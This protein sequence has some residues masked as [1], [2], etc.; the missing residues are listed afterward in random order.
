MTQN[1]TEKAQYKIKTVENLASILNDF[2]SNMKIVHCHGVFDLLHIGHIRHFE[3]AKSLGDI[4]VVTVTP[5]KYVNKGPHRPAFT[6]RLRVE[7]VASLSCVDYVAVNEWPTAVETIK[8]LQPNI[9]VKGSDYV[10]QKDDLTGKIVDERTA[11]ES[12]G[13]E[14][15]FT[16]NI[17]FSSSSLINRYIPV[18]SREISEYL[19]GFSTRYSFDAVLQYLKNAHKLKVLVV[20]EAIIDEYQ[21]CE[22]VA[23]SNKDPILVTRY[24]STEKH[25]GGILAVANHVANFCDNVGMVTMVGSDNSQENFIRSSLNSNIDPMFFF[26]ANSPTIVK[27]RFVENYLQQKLF[28]VYEMNDE[29]LDEQLDTSLSETL[30]DVIPQ[31]DVVIVVDY[32]HSMLSKNAIDVLCNKARFLAVNTQANAGNM[33]LNTIS[34]YPR[35]DYVC[36]AYPEILLEERMPRGNLREMMLNVSRKL[37][38]EQVVVTR[39][40][41]G[42]VCYSGDEGFVEVPAFTDLVVDRIGAGDAVFSL[43]SLCLSQ[44]APIEVVGFVGNAV[45]AQAVA[46]MG[47]RTAI[48]P[49]SLYKHIESLLK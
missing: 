43:T 6:E 10:D 17:T 45:G 49:V 35:A 39:G 31:Y 33:G 47:N 41:N 28:E 44:Q 3:Q 21:Y 14:A 9:Y 24:V 46:I 13:G 4:L 37:G 27:R 7:A 16:E 30:E 25:A 15:V 36:L 18:F 23:K 22:Q 1:G 48:E 42:S 40:K 34:K 2:R 26:K 29:E 20:G 8:I 32:G 19:T 12:I 11:V 38:C 5:D